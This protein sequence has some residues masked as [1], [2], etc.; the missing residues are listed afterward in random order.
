VTPEWIRSTNQRAGER[1]S[2]DDLVR[3]RIHAR[4]WTTDDE[5]LKEENTP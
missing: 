2:P 3:R 1:L 4:R 5:S